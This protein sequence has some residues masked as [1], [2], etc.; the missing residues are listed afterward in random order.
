MVDPRS[1]L[2]SAL[3][4]IL[5]VHQLVVDIC[6]QCKVTVPVPTFDKFRFRFRLHFQTTRSKFFH[7][8]FGK[9]LAFLV[10]YIVICKH[11]TGK[12]FVSF[13]KFIEKCERKKCKMKEIKYIVQLRFRFRQSKSYGSYGSGSTTLFV[14]T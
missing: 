9:N 12:N 6:S 3:I 5:L 13:I 4:N 8:I 1:E 11:F 14:A 7:K 2:C 10:F